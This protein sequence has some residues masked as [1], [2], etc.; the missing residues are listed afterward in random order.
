MKN[1][2][3]RPVLGQTI[4]RTFVQN[5]SA[6]SSFINS[7]NYKVSG[8]SISYQAMINQYDDGYLTNNE[9][10]HFQREEFGD[11]VSYCDPEEKNQ[12]L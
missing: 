12:L 5:K 11:S 2:I 1:F 6:K 7:I 8:I 10:K 4:D 9:I 3:F